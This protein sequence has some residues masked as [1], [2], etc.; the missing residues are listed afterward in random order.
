MAFEMIETGVALAAGG[1][2]GAALTWIVAKYRERRAYRDAVALLVRNADYLL[3]RGIVEKALSTYEEILGCVPWLEPGLWC[4]V[5]FK[6]GVCCDSL[7]RGDREEE[8]EDEAYLTRA[9][10]AYEEALK[11]AARKKD[12]PDEVAI[13]KNLG[14]AYNR[15][16]K[17]GE[18]EKNL[19]KAIDAYEDAMRIYNTEDLVLESAETQKSL[20]DAHRHL[21]RFR[22]GEDNLT[23]AIRYYLVSLVLRK[24][25]KY[26]IVS[27]ET[28]ND[29]GT[30]RVSL[31]RYG[32]DKEKI[33][34]EAISAYEKALRVRTIKDRPAEYAETQNNLG[35]AYVLLWG[36][37]WS[38]V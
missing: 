22:D 27:A 18:G 28:Q 25:D 11:I 6:Q 14:D 10:A 8:V 16:S 20:G 30:A 35:T 37:G 29:L 33:L 15:L 36:R 38:G 24:A 3:E 7:S 2:V 5:K 17:F 21:S 19:T 13:Q 31:S 26:P 23:K 9:V 4:R 1:I 32:E 34:N 12:L